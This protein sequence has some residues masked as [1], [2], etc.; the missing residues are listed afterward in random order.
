MS[1]PYLRHQWTPQT[2]LLEVNIQPYLVSDNSSP[3]V[4]FIPTR[5]VFSGT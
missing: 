2:V 1:H 5:F 3:T 4:I